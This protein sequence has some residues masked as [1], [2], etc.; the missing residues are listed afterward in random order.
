M[1]ATIE[2]TEQVITVNGHKAR[3]W[4]GVTEGGVPFQAV[5]A[6]VAVHKDA[7]NSQFERELMEHKPKPAVQVYDPRLF[8]D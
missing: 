8:L 7:D 5:I 6:R 2:S 4:E 3:I 1:K